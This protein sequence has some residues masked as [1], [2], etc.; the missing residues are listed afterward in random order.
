[1]NDRRIAGADGTASKDS[2]QRSLSAVSY[3]TLDKVNGI[4][5]KI[6]PARPQD[7]LDSL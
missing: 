4:D 5:G 3:E 2:I 1:M 6:Y 7:F